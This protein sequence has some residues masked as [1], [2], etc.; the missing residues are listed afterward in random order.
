MNESYE[1]WK[2]IGYFIIYVS[3]SIFGQVIK[4]PCMR[5][6]TFTSENKAFRFPLFS[7]NSTEINQWHLAYVK[8]CSCAWYFSISIEPESGCYSFNNFACMLLIAPYIERQRTNTFYEMDKKNK[9]FLGLHIRLK[10]FHR[11]GIYANWYQGFFW[12]LA[13][14]ISLFLCPRG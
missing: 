5:K 4:G 10:T 9:I 7:R 13:H 3:E 6:S 8:H 12:S 1:I 2:M 11:I 14:N